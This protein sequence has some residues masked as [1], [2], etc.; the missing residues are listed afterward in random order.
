[1]S[2]RERQRERQ[3]ERERERA[4]DRARHVKD[5]DVVTEA[6]TYDVRDSLCQ[7]QR[8]KYPTMMKLNLR[9]M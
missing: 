3:R 1:M 4:N 2:E 6:A 9:K 5:S 7:I 8:L